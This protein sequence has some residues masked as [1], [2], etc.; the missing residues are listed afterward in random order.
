MNGTLVCS[1]A[2]VHVQAGLQ[3]DLYNSMS[4]CSIM[5]WMQVVPQIWTRLLTVLWWWVG[6]LVLISGQARLLSQPWIWFGLEAGLCV[7][8]G[9]C[10]GFLIKWDFRQGSTFGWVHWLSCQSGQGHSCA[11]QLVKTIRWTLL[12]DEA[13]DWILRLESVVTWTPG[14][15]VSLQRQDWRNA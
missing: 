7:H 10:P 4:I 13:V 9:H 14:F 15:Q 6:L 3:P 1:L 2:G 8:A 12:L 5:K 11:W